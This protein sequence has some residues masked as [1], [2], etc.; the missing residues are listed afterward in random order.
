M[1]RAYE[2]GQ[3]YYEG[4]VDS[5]SPL[6]RWVRLEVQFR[7]KACEIPIEMIFDLDAALKGAYPLFEK[8]DIP[9]TTSFIEKDNKLLKLNYKKR[10]G[11]LGID[12]A[13]YWAGHSYKNLILYMVSIGYSFEQICFS[14][15]LQKSL[16]TINHNELNA[17]RLF[18]AKKVGFQIPKKLRL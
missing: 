7:N 18:K 8:I 4:D 12:H 13:L 5:R 16:D 9:K 17:E 15:V 14:I 1:F 11:W 6:G 10:V 2:K 3:M